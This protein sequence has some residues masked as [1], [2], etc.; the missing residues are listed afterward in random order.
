MTDGADT[1]AN[2]HASTNSYSNYAPRVLSAPITLLTR[3]PRKFGRDIYGGD[4]SIGR[5][6][7]GPRF[8]AEGLINGLDQIQ[9]E[10]V[11]DPVGRRGLT[12]LVGAYWGF[13]TLEWAVSNRK[14]IDVLAAGPFIAYLPSEADI[15]WAKVDRVVVQAAWVRDMYVH[16]MPELEGKI[17]IWPSGVDT[18]LWQ[19]GGPKT[20]DLIIYDKRMDPDFLIAVERTAER[21]GLSFTT[22]HYGS[23]TPQEYADAL[24]QSRAV[25]FLS[26]S[27]YQPLALFEAWS[28]DIPTLVWDRQLFDAPQPAGL[29]GPEHPRLRT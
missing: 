10:Y 6:P 25:I 3:T 29:R 17:A 16:D 21:A 4:V 20:T 15:D 2:A 23:H 5:G 9:A 18:D 8:M 28:C 12:R 27:E 19:P 1:K 26:S 11:V 13:D 7:S 22:L 24:R 14:R